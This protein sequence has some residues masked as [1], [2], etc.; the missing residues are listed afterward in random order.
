MSNNNELVE[1]EGKMLPTAEVEHIKADDARLIENLD[2]SGRMT[3]GEWKR[4]NNAYP[5]DEQWRKKS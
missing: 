1:F 3:F 2:G 4:Q 5:A